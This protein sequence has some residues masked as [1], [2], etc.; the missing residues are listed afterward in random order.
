MSH[1]TPT[2][3]DAGTLSGAIVVCKVGGLAQAVRNKT[4]TGK[5]T[6]NRLLHVLVF[7]FML[8]PSIIF[9]RAEFTPCGLYDTNELARLLL[10]GTS[11]L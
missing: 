1:A 8:L 7:S 11:D 10:P 3:D 4:S 2:E 9:L 5:N 6:I